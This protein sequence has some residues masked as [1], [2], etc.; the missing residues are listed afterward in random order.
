MPTLHERF[1]DLA[2]EAPES[3]TPTGIWHEGRR[4]ARAARI[5]TAVVV[6]AT[7]VLVAL[8]GGAAGR[9]GAA[10]PY[11]GRPDGAA[12]LPTQVH[13]AGRWL[14]TSTTPP[15]RLSMVIPAKQAVRSGLWNDY[16]WSVVGVS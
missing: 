10:P 2:E 4:R 12:V 15:G 7:L 8:V 14:G 11:A 9:R 3:P 16:R 1:A 6:V 5:G 13:Q